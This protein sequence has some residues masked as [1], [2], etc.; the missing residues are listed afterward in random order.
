MSADPSVKKLLEVI[1]KP[2]N[3][4]CADCGERIVRDDKDENQACHGNRANWSSY[5]LGVFLCVP[6]ASVHRKLGVHISKVTSVQLDRWNEDQVEFMEVNG[7]LKAKEKYE[8]DVPV[9]YRRPMLPSDPEVVR[10]QWIRGKYERQEFVNVNL[11]KY[12]TKEMEG[13]MWKK[14]RDK[15]NFMERRFVLS[16]TDYTLKYYNRADAKEPKA[17]IDLG[18]LHVAFCPDKVGNPNGMQLYFEQ[19]GGEIRNIFVYTDTG[20][21]IIDWYNAIRHMKY[22]RLMVAFPG[23]LCQEE[24]T[25]IL[26]KGDIIK[27]GWLHKTGSKG[28][29]AFRK[30]WVI[31]TH[32]RITY[33]ETP[34]DDVCKKSVVLGTNLSEYKCIEGVPPGKLEQGFS[35]TV[36]VPGRDFFFSAETG[37]ER[38]NWMTAINKEIGVVNE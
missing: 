13:V 23:G 26:N 38:K 24:I 2:G 8:L 22:N 32:K 18:K 1:K 5:N 20:K 4:V 35:F 3:N 21:E 29:E 15:Q 33:Y 12:R 7:N 19:K 31:L 37:T 10:E 14:L 34:L 9:S 30:R 27:E 6:C 16:E 17:V 25:K 36:R 11:Q 28:N